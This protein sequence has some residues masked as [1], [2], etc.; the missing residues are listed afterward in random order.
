M[1]MKA[2]RA[3]R[4]TGTVTGTDGKPLAPAIVFAS[5]TA[6]SSFNVITGQTRPDGTFTLTGL[7]PGEYVLRSQ[8]MGPPGEDP[9]IA[10]T[11]VVVSGDD[12]DNVQLTAVRPSVAK[13]R[14]LV[15]PAAARQLPPTV[16]FALFPAAPTGGMPM[17]PPPPAR[18]ADDFS[19]ELKSGPGL[20]RLNLGGF[21]VPPAGWT[22]RAVRVRGVDV[23]DTGIEFKPNE[24]IADLEVE[25]TNRIASLSGVV[26]NARGEGVKEYT[27]IVFAQ[28]KEKWTGITRYQGAG[29]P[30]QEG[31]FKIAMLPPGDYFV[32]AV[33]HLEQG[34]SGDPDFLER[35]ARDATRFSLSE[36]E[37]KTIQL[38]LTSL[39]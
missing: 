16:M 1:V 37:T 4:V 28:D 20:M 25:L 3:V 15:D 26:T 31:R 6:G 21:G 34:Q 39:P 27:A 8:R 24:D 22:I 12:L 10:T 7:G 2:I 32:V 11:K 19:F 5:E 23:T 33:D 30:D 17:P 35:A 18:V 29:R 36:G 14:V 13:G 38:K 9:E